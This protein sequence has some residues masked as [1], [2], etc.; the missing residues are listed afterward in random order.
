MAY[1]QTFKNIDN[2]LHTDEGCGSRGLSLGRLGYALN[3]ESKQLLDEILGM[4]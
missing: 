1:E 2:I 3:E 4:L